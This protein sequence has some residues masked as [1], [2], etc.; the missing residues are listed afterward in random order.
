M[1]ATNNI[2]D[3]AICAALAA[4]KEILEVYNSD[5]F[6]ITEKMDRS[7][8]TL[9][10]RRA[11][12]T[13]V[14]FLGSDPFPILSEEGRDIPYE[15]RSQWHLYWLIDPLDGTKE[16]IKRNGEFTVNIALI[17]NCRPVFGVVYAPALNEL[18]VGQPGKGSWSVINPQ[19]GITL[20]EVTTKGTSLP[21]SRHSERSSVTY[22]VV[23]SRSH[24]NDETRTYLDKLQLEKEKMEIV[25]KG[26]SLK[27]CMVASG[28]ADEYPRLGPTME[29]DIAAAHAVV[30][31]AGKNVTLWDS[32]EELAYN[33][34]E[35]LNPWFLVK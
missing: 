29:W 26:S 4:G 32:G 6:R 30:K 24:L 3:N 10:D 12:D 33:R 1:T 22:R 21:L 2:Y 13:I 18:Y 7:P 9:A 35:L 5:D 11:H 17:E 34:K 16:F 25:S 27:L 31:G 23:A 20:E 14:S 15:E 19:E 8:L 28:G